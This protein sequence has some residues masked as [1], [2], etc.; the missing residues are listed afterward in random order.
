MKLP[1]N[2]VSTPTI[3]TL[4]EALNELE[5]EWGADQYIEISQIVNI[6]HWFLINKMHLPE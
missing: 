5:K 6:P 2:M 4:R 1:N 3:A